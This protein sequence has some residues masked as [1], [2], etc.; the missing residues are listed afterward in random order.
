MVVFIGATRVVFFKLGGM[1]ISAKP[2]VCYGLFAT[3]FFVQT[4][5]PAK[6]GAT[7]KYFRFYPCHAQRWNFFH[8]SGKLINYAA[9]AY[10]YALVGVEKECYFYLLRLGV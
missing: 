7:K 5:L 8:L 4:C 6:A 9:R 3:I 2:N 1:G 10:F